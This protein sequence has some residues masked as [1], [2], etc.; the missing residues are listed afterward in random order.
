MRNRLS[1]TLATVAAVLALLSLV[2]CNRDQAP[3]PPPSTEAVYVIF[4][5]PWAIVPDPDNPNAVV[6]LAP[7]TSS[8]RP[9]AF[10]PASKILD[11]GVYELTV[12]SHGEPPKVFDLGDDFLRIDP[13]RKLIQAAIGNKSVRYAIRLPRPE[14]IVA[15]T[16]YRSRVD[17]QYP[18][19]TAFKNYA[20]SVSLIYHVSTRT[21]FRLEGTPDV[22]A[23]PNIPPP[24][25]ETPV[26]RFQIDPAD[27]TMDTC[28]NHSRQAF[29]DLTKLLGLKLFV[30]FYDDDDCRKGDPQA[31]DA[32]K[33]L[34]LYDLP[35]S[36]PSPIVTPVLTAGLGS[37][38]FADLPKPI[39]NTARQLAAALF[40]FHSTVCHT[41]MPVG[42]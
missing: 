25:L 42:P 39:V 6:A 27:V 26:I 21:G 24:I 34:L 22:G 3:P 31:S 18:P 12:P 32:K 8:H 4:E 9:L 2:S 35:F 37:V 10:V 19:Q 30:G 38:S 5:G 20:S 28:D 36:I 1:S 33:A 29:R 16:R 23:I 7:K 11:P 13:D 41:P 15:E 40:F 17:T 14:K